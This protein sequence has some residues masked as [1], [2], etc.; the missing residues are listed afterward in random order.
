[1]TMLVTRSSN[2]I[3]MWTIDVSEVG[4]VCRWGAGYLNDSSG[5]STN[6]KT[7]LTLLDKNYDD[8]ELCPNDSCRDSDM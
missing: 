7:Y 3:S 4:D 6:V 8:D 2:P 5:S 1:M